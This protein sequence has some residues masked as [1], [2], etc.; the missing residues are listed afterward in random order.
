MVVGVVV[1]PRSN[2]ELAAKMGKRMVIRRKE[3]GLTQEQ[4]AELAGIA[5]QQYNKAEKVKLV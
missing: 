2:P 1:M 5:H 3:L 4:V